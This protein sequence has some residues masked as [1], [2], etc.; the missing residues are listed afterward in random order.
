MCGS[1][2]FSQESRTPLDFL[3]TRT[4]ISLHACNPACRA[5]RSCEI[6]LR[7]SISGPTGGLHGWKGDKRNGPRKPRGPTGNQPALNSKFKV[8]YEFRVEL[9]VSWRSVRGVSVSNLCF[10]GLQTQLALA[11]RLEPWVWNAILCFIHKIILL[12][13]VSTNRWGGRLWVGNRFNFRNKELLSVEL[14]FEWNPNVIKGSGNSLFKVKSRL[15]ATPR[16]FATVRETRHLKIP[17]S[18]YLYL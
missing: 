9:A 13:V 18:F 7:K 4:F 3:G 14:L 6:S 2:R 12:S 10:P 1:L 16:S 15:M 8:K 17:E 5:L 11:R